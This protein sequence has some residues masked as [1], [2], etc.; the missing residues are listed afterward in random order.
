MVGEGTLQDNGLEE[1]T[2]NH[3]VVDGTLKVEGDRQ[4]AED[5]L[6]DQGVAGMDRVGRM[7]G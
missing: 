4:W 2:V 1:D 7:L 3:V 6:S 5:K